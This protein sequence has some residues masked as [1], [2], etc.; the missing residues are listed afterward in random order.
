[1]DLIVRFD[2]CIILLCWATEDAIIVIKVNG[3]RDCANDM[4]TNVIISIQKVLQ[5][6]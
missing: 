1:M 4:F 6:K 3:H 2:E 5:C